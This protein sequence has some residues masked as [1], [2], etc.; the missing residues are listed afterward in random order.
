MSQVVLQPLL[1][2]THY[3]PGTLSS[4]Q[5]SATR[6]KIGHEIYVN[7]ILKWFAMAWLKDKTPAA[8]WGLD[9]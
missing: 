3:Y 8:A 6:L 7:A 4:S 5:V 9:Y 1:G 2:L